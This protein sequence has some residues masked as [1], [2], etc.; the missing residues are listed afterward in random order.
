M[1]RSS[2]FTEAGYKYPK[3]MLTLH[4][5]TVFDWVLESFRY[6][7]KQGLFI[8][9]HRDDQGV[10]EFIHRHLQ[11]KGISRSHVI[12]ILGD[13]LGQADSVLLGL[14]VSTLMDSFEKLVIFNI[15]S[16]RP[17]YV[18]P[19][20]PE[21][22]AGYLEVFNDEGVSWSFVEPHSVYKGLVARTTE[23]IRI[24]N[25]CCT[26]LYSFSTANLFVKY[27]KH[28]KI[29][30]NWKNQSKEFYVA[31]L[32]ND[33]IADGLKIHYKEISK[34]EVIICGTPKEYE[35]LKTKSD[36]KKIFENK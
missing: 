6:Y 25:L 12:P 24:S 23:K 16:F 4:E 28:S 10:S 34:D 8:F 35:D 7:F 19:Q 30:G 9:I 36:L 32:Y 3:Y 13:T 2:R 22:S 11:T 5:R 27:A 31:P 1:G 17:G 14:E 29:S 21:D 26:G 20:L 33:L 15:D 18:F